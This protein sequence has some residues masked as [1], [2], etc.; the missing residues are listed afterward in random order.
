AVGVARDAGVELL[1]SGLHVEVL[2]EG[3]DLDAEL[4]GA[5]LQRLVGRGRVGMCV[6]CGHVADGLRLRPADRR[7]Q[8]QRADDHST[9]RFS[10]YF[11]LQLA[12]VQPGAP[13]AACVRGPGRTVRSRTTSRMRMT[14]ATTCWM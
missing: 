4:L 8:R 9:F 14:P 3:D 10:H 1:G 7:E 12:D 2:A 13:A 6:G 5:C 11:L